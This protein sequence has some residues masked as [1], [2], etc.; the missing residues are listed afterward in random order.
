MYSWLPSRCSIFQK[1]GHVAQKCQSETVE[2]LQKTSTASTAKDASTVMTDLINELQAFP[3]STIMTT[4][5]NEEG[6]GTV[7]LHEGSLEMSPVFDVATPQLVLEAVMKDTGE[8]T[9]DTSEGTKDTGEV[10]TEDTGEETNDTSEGMTDIGADWTI[11]TK[12]SRQ[13]PIRDRVEKDTEV[14]GGQYNA[15]AGIREE[16]EICG[17]KE[18]SAVEEEFEEK[19]RLEGPETNPIRKGP[20]S[21][22]VLKKKHK[23]KT[24][25]KQMIKS[26]DLI[27]ANLHAAA[28]KVSSRKL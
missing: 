15:L 21:Q 14:V 16:G 10:M 2:I 24:P 27:Q 26:K 3:A 17:D 13:S 20:S 8:D 1:W 22:Y 25:K 7:P 11:N 6:N 18:E 28:K 9:K 12:K 19:V 4:L 23:S 5:G